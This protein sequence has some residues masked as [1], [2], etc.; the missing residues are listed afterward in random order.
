M[1]SIFNKNN[2]VCKSTGNGK[3]AAVVLYGLLC[4]AINGWLVKMIPSV[5]HFVPVFL[6]LTL[7]IFHTFF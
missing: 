6:L 2:F 1:V 7:N 5:K 3:S 4:K